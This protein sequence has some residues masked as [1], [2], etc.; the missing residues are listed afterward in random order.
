M[1]LSCDLNQQLTLGPKYG[2]WDIMGEVWGLS[3]PKANAPE[4]G[5]LLGVYRDFG[6]TLRLGAGYS[7][8]GVSDDLRSTETERE[9]D[10]LT[11]IGKY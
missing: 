6:D 3:D 8:G 2:F 7:C 5:A 10:F 9:G 1:A 4:F 11:L